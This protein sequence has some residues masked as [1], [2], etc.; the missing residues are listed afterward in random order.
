MS[1]HRRDLAV[2]AESLYREHRVPGLEDT[3]VI[4][5]PAWL[6][7]EPV[8]V[9][10]IALVLDSV[11]V[12]PAITG[13]ETESA[14]VRPL[15]TIDARYHR[16]HDAVRDLAPPRLFEN[17]LCFRLLDVD[18]TRPRMRFGHMGFFDAIDTNEALAH[19]FAAQ[20]LVVD[21]SGRN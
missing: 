2:L 9:D 4:S 14:P 13:A 18:W 8:P 1:R 16:Y 3:G 10:E 20:H 21:G 15:A 17:R 7:A 12:D 6:P 11:Q 5:S 19:E